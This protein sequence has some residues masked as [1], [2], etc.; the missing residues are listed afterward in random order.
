MLLFC[1]VTDSYNMCKNSSQVLLP[2]CTHRELTIHYDVLPCVALCGYKKDMEESA[3]GL[4]GKE[5]RTE[6]LGFFGMCEIPSPSTVE[7]DCFSNWDK[8]IIL[9]LVDKGGRERTVLYSYLRLVYASQRKGK[10]A[11]AL[12]NYKDIIVGKP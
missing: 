7:S 11:S 12:H 10:Q 6:P 5:S 8:K 1:F 3:S 9:Q 4:C 2:D